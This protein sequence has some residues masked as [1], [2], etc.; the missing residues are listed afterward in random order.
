M[1]ALTELK[2][3]IEVLNG[4]DYVRYGIVMS[5]VLHERENILYSLRNNI[6]IHV[7][8][9]CVDIVKDVL[10]KGAALPEGKSQYSAAAEQA[11]RYADALIEELYK[12]KEE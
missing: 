12:D 5:A 3:S 9:S 10:F 2:Q 4:R 7:L 6:V 1:D 8:P 11:V